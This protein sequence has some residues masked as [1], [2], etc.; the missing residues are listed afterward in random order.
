MLGFH[1]FAAAPVSTVLA[2]TYDPG[3]E[4]SGAY[5]TATEPAASTYSAATEDSGAYTPA[6]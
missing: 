1:S 5:S 4:T 2:S 3:E 6:S